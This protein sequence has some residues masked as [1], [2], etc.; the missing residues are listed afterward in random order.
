MAHGFVL[1]EVM[2]A[3]LLA[4]FLVGPLATSMQNVVTLARNL[5]PDT[6]D[7]SILGVV[8]DEA[9]AWS[10][11]PMVEAALWDLGPELRVSVRSAGFG[12]LLVGA[13]ADGWS[14]GEWD[15]EGADQLTLSAPVWSELTDKELIIRV[16]EPQ[17][18][19]GPPW[20]TIVPDAWCVLSEESATELVDGSANMGP[21]GEEGAIVHVPA[22][23]APELKASW[24]STP[25]CRIALGL[26]LAPAASSPG[27]CEVDLAARSQSWYS[28]VGRG[29]DVYY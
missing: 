5:R 18:P 11:G 3:A 24:T 27:W 22:F 15:L 13:W 6:G 19:W 23:A 16:R 28:V 1:V 9:A 7:L 14:V 4:A 2:V 21:A 8:G 26:A 29:L 20:R 10:W 17:G 25:A 12:S